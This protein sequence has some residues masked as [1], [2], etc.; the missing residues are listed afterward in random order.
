MQLTAVSRVQHRRRRGGEMQFKFPPTYPM[1]SP[2]V[3]SG[4]L[5]PWL[6]PCGG[7]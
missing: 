5:R 1:E 2:E 6:A 4:P 7:D 3:R